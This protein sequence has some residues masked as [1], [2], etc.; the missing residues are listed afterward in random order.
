MTC[1]FCG[2]DER[3]ACDTEDGPCAWY[4][5]VPPVCTAENCA[6]PFVMWLQFFRFVDEL[7]ALAPVNIEI[8]AYAGSEVGRS[9][10][11]LAGLV[12]R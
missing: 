12:E 6:G 9:P 1:I 4:S 5:E 8:A 7:R 10:E 2:C 3:H 11:Y